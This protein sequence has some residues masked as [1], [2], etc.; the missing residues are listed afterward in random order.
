VPWLWIVDPAAETLEVF[1]LHA[2]AWVLASSH[3]GPDE[4]RAEPFE[5][6]PLALGALWDR[7]QPR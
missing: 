7:G 1:R 2:G 3:V 5:A 4:I 6:V